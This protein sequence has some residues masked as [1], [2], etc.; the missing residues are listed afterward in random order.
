[1]TISR[2]A[3][4][5]TSLMGAALTA[6]AVL[7][8]AAAQ[9]PV[10]LDFPSWQV[11]E[12][13]LGD[14]WRKVNAAFEQQN[15]GVTIDFV[16]IPFPQY[17][18]SLTTRFAAGSAPDIVHLPSRNFAQ[19]AAQ[20]WLAPIDDVL[21]SINVKANWTPLQS[22]MNWKGKGEGLLLMGYAMMLFYNEAMLQQAKLTLPRTPVQFL[23]AIA[24]L[25]DRSKGL[26]GIAD[27]TVEHPN[28]TVAAATWVYGEGQD[29]LKGGKWSFTDPGVI[30]AI[31]NY[32][33]A[34]RYAPPGMTTEAARPLFLQG[35][36]AFWRD[37]PWFSASLSGAPA[38]VRPNLKMT[39]MPFPKVPG[40]TSNSLHMPVGLDDRKRKL[41]ADFMRLIATPEMQRQYALSGSPAPR[42]NVL[43][44]ADIKA[45]PYLELAAHATAEATNIFP[46]I[47]AVRENYNAFSR[48]V[49]SACIRLQSS[50][51]KTAGVLAALQQ[52]LMKDVPV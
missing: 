40:G 7:R 21:D 31:E 26:F 49:T 16:Q 34:M 15:P 33:T 23:T 52:K 4:L 46:V 36:A 43:L 9:T 1:M 35:K 37:G 44:P 30:R 32:R 8:T 41:V 10:K 17:V 39:M 42:K 47:D 38:A 3:L 48:D 13:G 5:G 28:V 50:D 27:A 18:A 19:F 51:D 24:K 20:G 45:D 11:T 14:W 29:W 6:P 2:R 12:P 22:E 25:T